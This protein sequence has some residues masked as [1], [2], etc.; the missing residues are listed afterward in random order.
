MSIANM[1]AMVL[2]WFHQSVQFSD[3]LMRSAMKRPDSSDSE[4]EDDAGHDDSAGDGP[5]SE[6]ITPE[7]LAQQV[8]KMGSLMMV[9]PLCSPCNLFERA[10]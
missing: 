7:F 3:V 2:L 5:A 6:E 10:A 8:W 4:A 1:C 9:R